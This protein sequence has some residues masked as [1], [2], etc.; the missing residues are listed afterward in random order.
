MMCEEGCLDSDLVKGKIVLCD[1]FNGHKEVHRAGAEGSIIRDVLRNDVA[2]IV[3]LPATRLRSKD[4]EVVRLYLSST[5]NARAKILD[6]EGV[7]DPSAPI[8]GCCSSRGPNLILPAKLS[9][10]I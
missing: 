5:D 6:S 2:F 4:Y 8:V 9:S 3:P 7:K 10:Q 1:Q